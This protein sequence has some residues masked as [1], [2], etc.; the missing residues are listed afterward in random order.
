M[1]AKK[2]ITCETFLKLREWPL[3]FAISL[4]FGD[5][6]LNP[7][8][9]EFGKI[10]IQ[11]QNSRTWKLADAD[12]KRGF[13]AAVKKTK[14]DEFD[15]RSLFCDYETDFQQLFYGYECGIET[16]FVA[17]REFMKW[18]NE[19]GIDVYPELNEYFNYGYWLSKEYWKFDEAVMLIL[20]EKIP[21]LPH[22]IEN[23]FEIDDEHFECAKSLEKLLRD[24]NNRHSITFETNSAGGV[25]ACFFR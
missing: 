16:Y 6:P 22:E 19:N 7:P 20:S 13:L 21:P 23:V 1:S 12:I 5:N 3:D 8:R 9:N 18:C 24:A 25:G 4:I 14:L 10:L 17:P 15:F 2:Q 11:N